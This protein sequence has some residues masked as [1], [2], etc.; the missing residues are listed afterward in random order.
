MYLEPIFSSEDIQKRLE[1]EKLKFVGIDQFW[2]YTM[3][4]LKKENKPWEVI[5][6]ERL[7]LDFAQS[8]KTL[9]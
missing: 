4:K 8:N 9:E 5:E 2:R 3:E 6:N 1:L 7:K